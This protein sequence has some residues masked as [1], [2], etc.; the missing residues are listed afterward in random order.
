MIFNFY[1]T[2]ISHE[3]NIWINSHYFKEYFFSYIRLRNP[4]KWESIF[5]AKN[6]ICRYM[7]ICIKE[8]IPSLISLNEKI[9]W[10]WCLSTIQT[11]IITAKQIN[12]KPR[13]EACRKF[14]FVPKYSCF[15][16]FLDFGLL[17]SEHRY[18]MCKKSQID[19][20]IKLR[21]FNFDNQFCFNKMRHYA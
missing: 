19:Q 21:A 5:W 13:T 1:Q 17:Y 7:F 9:H 11:F 14:V 2:L 6:P 20:I 18:E 16:F 10:N 12:N 3:F 8:R 15:F 4:N